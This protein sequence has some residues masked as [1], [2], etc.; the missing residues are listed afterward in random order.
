MI[1]RI[2]VSS[3][4]VTMLAGC[5]QAAND[6]R[7]SL[8]LNELR[9]NCFGNDTYSC[10]SQT[11]DFNQKALELTDFKNDVAK[12]NITKL[13]GDEGWSL[14]K[15]VA[16]EFVDAGIDAL[17]DMRP[18]IFARIF[19]GDSQPMSPKGFVMTFNPEDMG[20]ALGEIQKEFSVRAKKVGLKPDDQALRSYQMIADAVNG[21]G[22]PSSVEPEPNAGADT[23][24]AGPAEPQLNNPIA[25]PPAVVM[26]QS[27]VAAQS[28]PDL[29][30]AINAYIA[31]LDTDGGVEYPEGRQII[32]V[33]LNGD[34]E[35]DAAVLYT[36]EGSGGSQSAYHTLAAFYHAPE[37][38]QA[39]GGD[40]AIS[41]AVREARDVGSR[42]IFIDALVQ[43]D[44]DPR[45]CPTQPYAQR[46][47]WSGEKFIEL[48]GA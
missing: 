13:F 17:E 36:I 31:G 2:L 16:D 48:P 44:D 47:Q 3:A 4:V 46:F 18:N 27:T 7:L 43:G 23:L 24:A 37:G 35:L 39:Q 40:A 22:S 26:A 11:I 9:Q 28:F 6:V 15:D 21:K 10:R 8:A 5:G 32:Q 33:D 1:E 25:T 29:T 34:G 19:F 41:G 20:R 12:E 45:C 38:W 14:Y 30:G 42:T